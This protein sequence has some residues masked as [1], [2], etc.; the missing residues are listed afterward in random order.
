[1][2]GDPELVEEDLS[3]VGVE[4]IEHHWGTG[5]RST[6]GRASSHDQGDRIAL[7]SGGDEVQGRQARL[8]EPVRVVDDHRERPIV[9]RF[10][11]EGP[12]ANHGRKVAT[13]GIGVVQGECGSDRGP[14]WSRD[15]VVVTLGDEGCDQ[16]V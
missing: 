10:G 8:I 12:R 4:R 16:L 15:R 9:G 1:M 7:H 5:R 3:V 13:G 6:L 14:L 2:V 11:E